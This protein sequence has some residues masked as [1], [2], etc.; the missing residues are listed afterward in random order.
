V[1]FQSVHVDFQSVHV[2]FYNLYGLKMQIN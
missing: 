1:D 2:D